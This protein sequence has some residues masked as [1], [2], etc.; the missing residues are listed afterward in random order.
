M[1]NYSLNFIKN[2]LRS[3]PIIIE[4]GMHH[5]EDTE[6]F[7]K[8]F[9]DC[10]II[11]FEPDKRCAEII[12]K[13]EFDGFEFFRC[14]LSN[15]NDTAFFYE[16]NSN[17]GWDGSG[18]IKK[19]K[20]HKEIFPHIS[21]DHGYIVPTLTLDSAL[22]TYLSDLD[23]PHPIVSNTIDLIWIDVQG[24]EKDVLEGA[25]R[26]LEKTKYLHFEIY[27]GIEMY[28][29]QPTLKDIMDT[30]GPNWSIVGDDG[31]GN[32]IAENKSVNLIK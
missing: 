5:G 9:P 26:T 25:K 8:L 6:I 1:N 4:I 16:S 2:N 27:D 23:Y 32:K 20:K 12:L 18:S 14:A 7:K 11:G 21:F 24:A 13:K 19:P 10:S 15:K 17:E 30:L 3:K 31:E 29:G 28:E 22:S